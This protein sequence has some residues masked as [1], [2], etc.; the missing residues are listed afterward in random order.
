VFLALDLRDGESGK[1]RTLFTFYEGSGCSGYNLR[2]RWQPDGKA[3]QLKGYTLGFD[4]WPQKPAAFN[5][6]YFP[7]DDVMVEL[8]TTQYYPSPSWWERL[9]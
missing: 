3:V 6:A 7:D 2:A 8:E 9:F 1:V 4:Y 5:F